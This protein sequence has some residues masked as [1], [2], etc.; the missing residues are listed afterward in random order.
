MGRRLRPV[1]EDVF[2]PWILVRSWPPRFGLGSSTTGLSR[3]F[4]GLS[5]F[6]ARVLVGRM[7]GCVDGGLGAFRPE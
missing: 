7:F 4:S 1:M 2:V 3:F 5:E 6:P